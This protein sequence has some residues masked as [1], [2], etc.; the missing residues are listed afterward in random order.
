M[1]PARWGDRAIGY[2]SNV[3]PVIYQDLLSPPIGSGYTNILM[4]L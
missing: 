3:Q 4:S 2:D 1:P